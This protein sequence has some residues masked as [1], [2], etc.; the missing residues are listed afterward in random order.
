MS[1]HRFSGTPPYD[2]FVLYSGV[3]NAVNA[4]LKDAAEDAVDQEVQRVF[5]VA[6]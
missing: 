1:E 5:L 2:W 6:T 4:P 3:V